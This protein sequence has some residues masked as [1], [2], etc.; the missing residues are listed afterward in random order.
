MHLTLPYLCPGERRRDAEGVD[1]S[2]L[3][4]LS[5]DDEAGAGEEG[6]EDEDGAV[7]V[8]GKKVGGSKSS[9]HKTASMRISAVVSKAK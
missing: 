1:V 2:V 8:G 9:L 5:D 6:S 4:Q 7:F 3:E